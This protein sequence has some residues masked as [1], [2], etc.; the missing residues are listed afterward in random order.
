MDAYLAA[1]GDYRTAHAT[2]PMPQ[3]DEDDY[4]RRSEQD[5]MKIAW[6]AATAL[7]FSSLNPGKTSLDGSPAHSQLAMEAGQW[8]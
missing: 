3:E 7:P 1:F 2:R 5:W 4:Y 6:I 8:H